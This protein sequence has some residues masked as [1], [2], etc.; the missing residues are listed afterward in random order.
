MTGECWLWRARERRY[1]VSDV[2]VP[3]IAAGTD[4]EGDP[5]FKCLLTLPDGDAL[6]VAE[7]H[8][9]PAVEAVRQRLLSVLP[10]A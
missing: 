6:T 5:Y 10:P 3:E 2:A 1:R 7:A 4:S 9:R 8:A